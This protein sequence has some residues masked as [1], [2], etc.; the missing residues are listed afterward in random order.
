GGADRLEGGNGNDTF[1]SRPNDFADATIDGGAGSDR[2]LLETAGEGQNVYDLTGTAL[3]SIEEIEFL[4]DGGDLSENTKTVLLSASQIGG[5]GLSSTLV[6]D[7]NDIFNSR[8]LISISMDRATSLDLSG[9]AFQDWGT[10]NSETGEVITITGDADAE[11][12]TGSRERDVISG[13]GGDDTMVGGLGSDTFIWNPGDGSDTIEGGDGTDTLDFNGSNA[14]EFIG[15]V[16]NGSRLSF[17]RDVGNVTMD[18]NGVEKVSFAAGA[19]ADVIVVSNLTGTGVT[20]VEIDLAAPGG[21]GDGAVDTAMVSGTNGADSIAVTSGGPGQVIVTGPAATTTLVSAEATD[22]L[23]VIGQGGD[24]VIDASALAAGRISLTIDAGL[25]AEL[26][27]GSAGDDVIIGGDGN[28]TA[29]MGD[30]DDTFTWNPGDDNDT[31]NGQGG[32]DTLDFKGANAAEQI[33]ISANGGRTTFTRDVANVSMDLDGVEKIQFSAFGGADV[34]TIGDLGG[35]GVEQVEIDLAEAANL[36]EADTI[37]VNGSDGSDTLSLSKTQVDAKVV[38]LGA[39]AGDLLQVNAGAGDD[40]FNF[41]PRQGVTGVTFDGGAGH[42][43]L[44]MSI[45]GNGQN[46]YDLTGANFASIDEIEFATG[47]GTFV[48]NTR[49]VTISASQLGDGALSSALLINGDDNRN[50]KDSVAVTMGKATTLD[51]SEWRFDGWGSTARSG[52]S[53]DSEFITVT[54][55]GDH[56]TITGSSERDVID[57]RGGNDTMNGGRGNDVLDGGAG[58]DTMA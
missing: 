50:S 20:E 35:T 14:K 6:I 37:I 49:T 57:G 1:R 53:S 19:G 48:G 22:G 43:T 12:I 9:W 27:S 56:E 42:N 8:D 40:I 32:F 51:L 55:D 46:S 18:V 30:G 7:G 15:L 17:T 16:T 3:A 11:T 41:V 25:G 2:L 36:A 44:L 58:A 28:E 24:D 13:G 33:A 39:Q 45:G 5:A 54:G 52:N 4:T 10:T 26:I 29:F 34:I 21:G 38:V 31:I 23:I 47:G